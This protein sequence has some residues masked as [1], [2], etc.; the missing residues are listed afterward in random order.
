M[1]IC[2]YIEKNKTHW[3]YEVCS[4]SNILFFQQPCLV[5]DL[6]EQVWLCRVMHMVQNLWNF[7]PHADPEIPDKWTYSGDFL[8][9][10]FPSQKNVLL[11]DNSAACKPR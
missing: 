2:L 3:T 8:H 6:A 7:L 11:Q 9:G 10:K 5:L 1:G 4:T